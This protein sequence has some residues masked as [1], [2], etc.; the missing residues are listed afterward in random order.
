MAKRSQRRA[1]EASSE[2]RRSYLKHHRGGFR[3]PGFLDYQGYHPQ[4]PASPPTAYLLSRYANLYD[5]LSAFAVDHSG[6]PHDMEA[7]KYAR[8]GLRMMILALGAHRTNYA[9]AEKV[10]FRWRRDTLRRVGAQDVSPNHA[11]ARVRAVWEI[12]YWIHP[13]IFVYGDPRRFFSEVI[14]PRESNRLFDRETLFT[15]YGDVDARRLGEVLSTWGFGAVLN[16]NVREALEAASPKALN[17]ALAVAESRGIYVEGRKKGARDKTARKSS[18]DNLETKRSVYETADQIEERTGESQG[19]VKRSV[20]I[21]AR[22]EGRKPSA[23]RR[24]ISRAA[25]REK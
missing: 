15:A 2:E 13:L 16:P 4:R 9:E 7:V 24:R 21:V 14:P 20:A 11:D 19:A 18:V 3:G 17:E 25:A 10:F 8:K 23:I 6:I 1:V 12:E 22:R 5:A